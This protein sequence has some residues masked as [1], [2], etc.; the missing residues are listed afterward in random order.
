MD[1]RGKEILTGQRSSVHAR[2]GVSPFEIATEMQGSEVCQDV[3]TLL[4]Q[5]DELLPPP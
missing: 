5:I 4:D 1:A 3:I 2:F